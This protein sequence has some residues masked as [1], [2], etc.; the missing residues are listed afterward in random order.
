MLNNLY[1][2]RHWILKVGTHY[3]TNAATGRCDESLRVYCLKTSRC[4]KVFVRCT[5]SEFGRV[6]MWTSFPKYMTLSH[7]LIYNLSQQLV[8][9]ICRRRVHTLRQ[10]CYRSFCGCD[11]SHKFKPV[12]ICAT[13]RSDKILSQRLVC[14]K[15]EPCHTTC[16]S[17]VSSRP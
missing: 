12:W 5:N 2:W 4:N 16:C 1:I 17:D 8:A 6:G 9:A 7:W 10:R 13:H 15:N 3:A 11:V 14:R